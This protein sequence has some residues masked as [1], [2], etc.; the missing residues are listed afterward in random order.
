METERDNKKTG[1]RETEKDREIINRRREI[2]R[3]R[4]R[5]IDNKRTERERYRQ[6]S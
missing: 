2:Y 5:G 3:Q 4:D 1:Q 6:E